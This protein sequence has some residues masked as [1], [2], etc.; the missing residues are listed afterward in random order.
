MPSDKQM[1]AK[2]NDKL[3]VPYE[4]MAVEVDKMYPPHYVLKPGE[5]IE[6]HLMD[7]E[8]FIE[9]CGWTTEEYLEEYIHRSLKELF[10]DNREMN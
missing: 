4:V 5:T 6:Q 10:P 1:S 8:T 9:S 2:A 3:R 7:I